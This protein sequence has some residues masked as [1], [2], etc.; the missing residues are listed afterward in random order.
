MKKVFSNLFCRISG[1]KIM[2]KLLLAYI[3]IGLIPLTLLSTYMAYTSKKNIMDQHENQ[4]Q[5]ENKR[6][7]NILFNII[8]LATNISDTILYDSSLTS[9][10]K[11]SYSSEDEVYKAYRNYKTIASITK[12]YTELSSIKIFVTNNTLITSGPFVKVDDRTSSYDW[13]KTV[14]DSSGKLM[15]IYDNTIETGSSLRLIRRLPVQGTKDYAIIVINISTNY[16]RFIINSDTVNSILSIENGISFFS[17]KHNEIGYPPDALFQADTVKINEPFQA[18]YL[19]KDALTYSSILN[20]P[21]SKSRFQITTFDPL[22]YSHIAG[23]NINNL[24]IIII[25]LMVPLLMI[26]IFSTAFNRRILILRRE[27]HKIAN[28]DFNIIDRFKSKDELGELYKDMQKTILS[29]QQ[30]SA[31]VYEEK[32]LSQ[33]LLNYQQQIEFNLLASQINPHF[34]YNTLETIRMQL[35]IKKDYDAANIVMLLGKYLRHNIEADSSLVLLTSELEYIN[36]YMIIQ[37]FRF[38]DRINY[39]INLEDNLDISNY[40]ILPLLLQPIVENAFVH[41]LEGKK[42]GGTITINISRREDD[43]IISVADDGLGM[44]EDTLKNL[45]VSMNEVNNKSK[46]HI[47]LHNVQQRIKLYYG[48]P[49]GLRINSVEKQ[50]TVITYQL[51]LKME[52]SVL[53]LRKSPA[54]QTEIRPEFSAESGALTEIA[55]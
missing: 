39:K 19:G 2:Y 53:N 11:E 5:A 21:K 42:T 34:L 18:K 10:L 37:H 36:I 43:L 26:I 48:E 52:G 32:L 40:P 45:S 55:P 1:L 12:S 3:I 4:V 29:I 13:Y 6:V 33:K 46:S 50:Y 28:G 15:W 38:G 30:L 17:N 8:Y 23:S 16:L 35:S 22:T 9:L 41:G 7:R 54:W 31:M 44:S 49:Y 25:N 27:M 47:G 14:K 51:P 20:A 24:R